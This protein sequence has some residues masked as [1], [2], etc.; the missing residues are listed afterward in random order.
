MSH[1]FAQPC[2][3]PERA[4]RSF[5]PS[6]PVLLSSL[7]LDDAE[8]SFVELPVFSEE[9]EAEGELESVADDDVADDADAYGDEEEE[10]VDVLEAEV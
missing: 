1:D 6:H 4:S 5:L 9:E 3:Q 8:V 10:E 2:S 7:E